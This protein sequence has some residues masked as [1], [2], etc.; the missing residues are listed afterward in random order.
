MEGLAQMIDVIRQ[1]MDRKPDRL[2]FGGI[3]LTMYDPYL[4]L[5]REVDARGA[6][7]FRRDCLLDRDP[8]RRGGVRGPQP[9]PFGDG[10]CPRSR[11]ALGLR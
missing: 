8:A 11:G 2:Q 3:V 6:R 5:T 7:F 4:E 1:V 9:R 10:L